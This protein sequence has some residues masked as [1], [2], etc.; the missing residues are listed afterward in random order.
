MKCVVHSHSPADGDTEQH[1]QPSWEGIVWGEA[2]ACP[3]RGLERRLL[4]EAQSPSGGGFRDTRGVTLG[5]GRSGHSP[6]CF[7]AKQAVNLPTRA[8]DP[9]PVSPCAL[10]AEFEI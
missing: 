10:W 1:Q 6:V 5:S 4:E 8:S 2:H 3:A 7:C 9:W